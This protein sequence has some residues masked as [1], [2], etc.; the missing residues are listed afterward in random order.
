M[1]CTTGNGRM[2]TSLQLGATIK[3]IQGLLTLKNI[4]MWQ[5]IIV[6]SH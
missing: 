2:F 3:E 5:E 6:V 4:E 1:S